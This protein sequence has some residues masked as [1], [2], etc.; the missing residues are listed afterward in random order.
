[1][2]NLFYVFYGDIMIEIPKNKK[3]AIA[4]LLPHFPDIESY[5][6]ENKINFKRK[7]D[8]V[9]MFMHYNQ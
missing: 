1:R 7:L 6:K 4:A 3:K 5:S 8:L 2:T 9:E